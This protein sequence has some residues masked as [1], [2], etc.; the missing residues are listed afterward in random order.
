MTLS[1]TPLLTLSSLVA[2]GATIW[3][4]LG[5]DGN[6]TKSS[7]DSPAGS[8]GTTQVS[9]GG[10]TSAGGSTM[11]G[12]TAGGTT[13][14]PDM[15]CTSD[16][17]CKTAGLLCN[18]TV[19]KCVQC[20]QEADC[21]TSTSGKLCDA[22]SG[23]CVA[24]NTASDCE[25]PTTSE[26]VAHACVKAETCVNSR[27]CTTAATPVCNRDTSRC[28][29]CLDAADC[30]ASGKTNAVCAAST[31]QASCT[32]SD[33]CA[34]GTVCNTASSPMYCVQCLSNGD[35]DEGSTCASGKCVIGGSST[36][37][38]ITA[39]PCTGIPAFTGTQ[40]VD[41]YADDFCGVPGFALG[42]DASAGKINIG[43]GETTGATYP[44]K[45][46]YRVAWSANK[47]HVH[48]EVIDPGV[49]P[50]ANEIWNGDSVEFMISTSA[51]LTGLTSSDANTLHVIGSSTFGVTVKASGN[52]G[53]HT[54]IT[55]PS[56]FKA[57]TTSQGYAIEVEMPWPGGATVASGTP[58]YFDAAIN[59][60]RVNTDGSVY[61][62]AQAI[63]FQGTN[64]TSTSCT[65]TGNDIAP[66]CDD[67]LWCPTKF[68]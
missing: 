35:C 17:E 63:L 15:T 27:D 68:Q 64:T 7:K 41:G 23:R 48:I 62:N 22:T 51:A 53:A 66:F 18:K 40:V 44:E 34:E 3:G 38:G 50:N 26:C 5:C 1:K 14:L 54:P 29:E 2:L 65:G 9:A 58:M 10:A 36:C 56:Q 47:I 24:C 33:D 39:K 12:T 37:A 67:R 46:T 8:G 16:L 57:I 60:A 20:L 25:N 32:T 43:S 42:F 59:S 45:A 55:D 21:A 31:C 6:E 30:A 4:P 52:S 13:S 28:V 19:S 61:R 11:T 49:A